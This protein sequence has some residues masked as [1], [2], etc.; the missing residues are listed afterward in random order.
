MLSSILLLGCAGLAVARDGFVKLDFQREYVKQISKRQVAEDD[1][2]ENVT[3]A[4]GRSVRKQTDDTDNT[5]TE[6]SFTGW[7]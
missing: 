3:L 2:D 5:L 1:L 6:N 4:Q 7:T